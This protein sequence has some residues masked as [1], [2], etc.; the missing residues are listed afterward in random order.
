MGSVDKRLGEVELSALAKVV[1]ERTQNLL[2]DALSYPF[3]HPSVARLVGRVI[4]G[5]R[6]PGSAAPQHPQDPV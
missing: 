2:K 5:Q 4:A 1:R 3:L 6:F